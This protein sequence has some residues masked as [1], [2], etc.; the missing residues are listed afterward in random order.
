MLDAN[1][2]KV[3]SHFKVE[4]EKIFFIKSRGVGQKL[5]KLRVVGQKLFILNS[6][7]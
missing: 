4:R 7:V 5:I 3:G 6:Y 1:V 2:G